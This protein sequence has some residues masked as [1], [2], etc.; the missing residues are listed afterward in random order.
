MAAWQTSSH[1]QG[2]DHPDVKLLFQRYSEAKDALE[3]LLPF[4][5][6]EARLTKQVEKNK[7]AINS[8]GSHID[9]ITVEINDLQAKRNEM[10]KEYEELKKTA[11]EL[12][13]K[14]KQI[15]QE[16]GDDASS[17]SQGDDEEMGEDKGSIAIL[18]A[19]NR[20]L[21][22]ANLNDLLELVDKI[23]HISDKKRMDN[24]LASHPSFS[25]ATPTGGSKPD[26]EIPDPV[27]RGR[28]PT[29]DPP[30]AKSARVD[31][32]SP[33]PSRIGA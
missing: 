14:L 28:S 25:I 16:R 22:D 24:D 8:L 12:S 20:E 4:S 31:S 10:E 29:I 26:T 15:Q 21:E 19:D 17:S 9:E 7:T 2:A 33:T 23:R 11:D 32:G 1:H 6:R 30:P 13:E 27:R 3:N 18:L 5:Q